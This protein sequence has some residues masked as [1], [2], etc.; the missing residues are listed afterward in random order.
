M[1]QKLLPN[2]SVLV[3]YRRQ[4]LNDLRVNMPNDETTWYPVNNK[5]LLNIGTGPRYENIIQII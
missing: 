5:S 4:T 1:T 2:Y 3:H